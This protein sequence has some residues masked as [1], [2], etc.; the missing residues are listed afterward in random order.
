MKDILLK[1][2]YQI[3]QYWQRRSLL[4][5]LLQ[6]LAKNRLFLLQKLFGGKS[7]QRPFSAILRLKKREKK[8][9]TAIELGGGG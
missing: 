9:S 5:D 3:N 7:C 4:T 8:V 1:A 2:T 6:Y